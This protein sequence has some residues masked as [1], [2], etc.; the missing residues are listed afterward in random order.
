LPRDPGTAMLGTMRSRSTS[1]P[2]VAA[3]LVVGL[4]APACRMSP[5]EAPPVDASAWPDDDAALLGEDEPASDADVAE[6][7]PPLRTRPP[8]AIFRD[9]LERATGA[10]PAYLLR[11][12]G[13]EPFRH[14]GHFIGWEITQLFP[15]D[16]GLCVPGRCDL[17]L[18]DVILGVNGHRLATPQ[19]LSDALEALPRWTQLRVQ[20]LREGKRRE[21]TYTIL[22]DPAG[23][24]TEGAIPSAPR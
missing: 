12:L 9:E 11:Q 17:A 3:S 8:R 20:S 24:A 21:T 23:A 4:G 1:W 10:G 2:G 6:V 22:D 19:D 7:G 18:G 14:Q 5:A 13:P 16:P 15:D